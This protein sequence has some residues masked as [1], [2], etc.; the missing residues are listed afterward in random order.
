[1]F[2]RVCINGIIIDSGGFSDQ[3]HFFEKQ[4]VKST[5]KH[6]NA[7]RY[8]SSS[9]LKQT[10]Q[11]MTLRERGCRVRILVCETIKI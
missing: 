9:C 5:L 2:K 6:D 10:V 3:H 7:Y 8:S 4:I 1:M 11:T